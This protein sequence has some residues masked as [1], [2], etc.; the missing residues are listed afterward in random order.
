M[1]FVLRA[2]PTVGS[3]AS[4]PITS[5]GDRSWYSESKAEA[6]R[7]GAMKEFLG[8]FRDAHISLSFDLIADK[9]HAFRL[10][11]GVAPVASNTTTR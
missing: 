4:A 3:A 2:A 7:I 10:P 11:F 1:A 8:V 5:R 6:E 9:A